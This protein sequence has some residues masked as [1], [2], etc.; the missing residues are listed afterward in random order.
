MI[1]IKKR[2]NRKPLPKEKAVYGKCG[3][4]C[5]LCI[6]YNGGTISEELRKELEERL[7]RVYNINDWSMRCSGC[8]TTGCY[9]ELCDPRKCAMEKGSADCVS[10]S[11]YP[12]TNATAGYNKLEPKHILVDDVTWKRDAQDCREIDSRLCIN[13]RITRKSGN[14]L[15]IVQ[16]SIYL[17]YQHRN[18]K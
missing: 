4:R 14:F 6:H 15:I 11:L 1:L 17:A 9:T 13:W 10:C 8:G 5:D 12:C 18:R 2:P 7:T 16:A 3:H